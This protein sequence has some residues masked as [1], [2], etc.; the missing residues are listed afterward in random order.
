M[1]N[2][3]IFEQ[4]FIHNL[5]GFKY[6]HKLYN[7]KIERHS[8]LRKCNLMCADKLRISHSSQTRSELYK[9]AKKVKITLTLM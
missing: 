4:G 1:L 3:P 9:I 8:L 7:T 5:D 6:M 2:L